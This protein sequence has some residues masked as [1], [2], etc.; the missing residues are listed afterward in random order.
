MRSKVTLFLLSEDGT[1]GNETTRVSF[2]EVDE[3]TRL[4]FAEA[5]AGVVLVPAPA[6]D[7][8]S[9]Y[10]DDTEWPALTGHAQKKR[11]R[12]KERNGNSPR[13]IGAISI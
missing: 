4:S 6:S 2:I 11:D 1:A 7:T 12:Q 9:G 8:T 5:A 13:L 3:A 10:I